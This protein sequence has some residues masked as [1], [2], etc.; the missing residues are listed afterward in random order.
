MASETRLTRWLVDNRHALGFSLR[1]IDW[2]RH[3]RRQLFDF[4]AEI[5]IHG[6]AIVGRG[7]DQNERLA[8]EKACAE[9]IERAICVSLGISSKGMAVHISA[10]L[11]IENSKSEAIER[12]IFDWHLETNYPFVQIQDHFFNDFVA[13]LVMNDGTSIRLFRMVSVNELEYL[14]CLICE[15]GHQFLGMSGSKSIQ[16]SAS[17]ALIEAL[18]NLLAYRE[19]SVRFLASVESDSDLWCADKR[20]IG[21]MS[22]LFVDKFDEKVVPPG[23]EVRSE[24]INIADIDW[25]TGSPVFAARSCAMRMS[26]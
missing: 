12:S 9:A 1:E 19:D 3:W 26:E 21:S 22:H 16:D 13:P 20:F 25:L 7:T 5:L 10:Q 14:I 23:I 11:A 2:S 8:L 15:N 6:K 17:K 24:M 4:E 18:R